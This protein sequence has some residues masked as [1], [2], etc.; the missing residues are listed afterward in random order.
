[1]TPA[2]AM[3]RSIDDGISYTSHVFFYSHL[4][5]S[6]SPHAALCFFLLLLAY[7]RRTSSL[8]A[9]V[10]TCIMLEPLIILVCFCS[11]APG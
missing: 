11:V 1:M 8:H 10:C 9:M 3:D 4:L 2:H 5:H 7:A 6:F